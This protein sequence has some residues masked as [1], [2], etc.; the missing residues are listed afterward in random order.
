MG[1]IIILGCNRRISERVLGP[2]HPDILLSP[3]SLEELYV[4]RG[5]TI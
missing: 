4:E 2:E 1:E 3:H 5:F